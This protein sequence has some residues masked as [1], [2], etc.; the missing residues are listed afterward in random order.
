[1]EGDDE[2]FKGELETSLE[3]VGLVDT[4]LGV[5][6]GV[7]G[8]VPADVSVEGELDPPVGTVSVVGGTETGGMVVVPALG[9]LAAT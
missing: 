4:V 3:V 1:M 9:G 7:G 2:S 6:G 8:W 5:E